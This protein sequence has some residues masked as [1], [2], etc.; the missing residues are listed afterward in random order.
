[1]S[2]PEI[3]RIHLVKGVHPKMQYPDSTTKRGPLLSK[4]ARGSTNRS[5]DPPFPRP[6]KTWTSMV[7][8]F[9]GTPALGVDR[10]GALV[11][12]HPPTSAKLQPL[13]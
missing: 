3:C 7:A 2:T 4:S 8:S 6:R 1:M 9:L 5:G 13:T 11:L 10:G 12:K